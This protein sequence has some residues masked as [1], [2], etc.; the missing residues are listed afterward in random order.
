[1]EQAPPSPQSIVPDIPDAVDAIV[2]RCLEP[3]PAKRFRRPPTGRGARP[4][5]RQRGADP[6]QRAVGLRSRPPSRAAAGALGGTWWYS[7]QGLPPVQHEPV[8][9]VIADFEN[10][11]GDDGFDRTLEPMLRRALEGAGFVTAL[12]R[13]G[14]RRT[15]GVEPPERSTRSRRARSRSSRGWGSC[16]PAPS[17]AG[18]RLRRL[19][20]GDPDGDRRRDRRGQSRTSSKDEVLPRRQGWSANV[21]KALG[22]ETSESA[23]IFAMASLSATSLDVVREYAAAQEAASNNRFEEARQSSRRPWSIDPTFG[24]GYQLLA[25]ASRNLGQQQDA[26]RYI[27]EA[28]RYLDGMTERER[29]STRGM[30]Y[31]VTG[32]Y[33]QCVKEYG[34]LIARY[35]A[36]VAAH[37]QLA[38]CSTQLRDMPRA[39]DEMRQ[40]VEISAEARALPGQPGAVRQLRRRVPDRREGSAASRSRTPMRRLPW[41]SRRWGRASC[42]RRTDT[43]QNLGTLGA[44]GASFAA[45][46]LGDLAVYEGRFT[47]AATD[48]RAGSGRRPD[49]QEPPTGRPRSSRPSPTHILRGQERLAVAAAAE[50]AGQQ[51]A[52]EDPVPR[53]R[54]CS[55][56]PAISPLR[57]AHG[58]A[59]AELQAEPQAYAKL[60]EGE[61]ALQGG[62]GARGDQALHRGATRCSTPGSATSI[63]AAP[64][65]KPAPVPAGRLRVRSLP[66]ASGRG[67]C[68]CSSTRNR[69]TPICR[70]STTTR[71]GSAKGCRPPGSPSR[72]APIS[73]SAAGP[74]RIRSC[75]KC[76]G[77]P[78]SDGRLR[79]GRV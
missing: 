70:P 28:L 2:T 52:G 25:V 47:D 44:L 53:R 77:A 57:A 75:R 41:R 46:G 49:G 72:I 30:F 69:P 15:L 60:I 31:R 73:A 48:P 43:Y 76:A 16:C 78:G 79:R 23:Q 19:G 24:I 6:D 68:R 59:R 12:D 58:R 20:Q 10:L 22:D 55:S 21:R 29:F 27:K 51:P 39:L 14:I 74:A 32:D 18:Q 56:R 9:V 67:A 37:N 7:R 11:T 54:G 36:D 3:D 26:E 13:T 71:A 38:L 1:M 34:E 40:V 65:S 4:S 45:S 8:S 50:G 42:R 62:Q 5:G 63:S 61:I 17:S 64:T 33:Q 66:Q 35:A